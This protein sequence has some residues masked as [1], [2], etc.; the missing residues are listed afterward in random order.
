V[1]ALAVCA[2]LRLDYPELEVLVL[3]DGSTDGTARRAREAGGGD[4][5]LRVLRDTQ[6]RGKAERLN[7]GLREARG[8]LVLAVDSDAHLH[9]A[10]L[11][12]LV[13]NIERSPRIAAVA[14]D[15][16]ITNRGSVLAG[17]QTL[18]FSSIVGLIRRTQALGGAVGTVAGIIGLFRRDAVLAVGGYDARM[19]TEDIE[20][21]HRL[22]LAGWETEYEPRALIGMQVPTSSGNAPRS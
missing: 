3:D 16:R 13:Q 20:L 19:A 2:A 14:G 6:N 18:E 17:L 21:T 1:I 8:G 12:M 11:Q 15:P 9:P 4:P 10:A 7:A 5:R 22:L